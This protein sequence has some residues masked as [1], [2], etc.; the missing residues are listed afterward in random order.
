MANV[1][2]QLQPVCFN[3]QLDW[4]GNKKG[5]LRGDEVQ[6]TIYVATPQ[7]FGGEGKDWSPEHLFLGSLSSCFMATFLNLA[8]KYQLPVSNFSCAASGSVELVKGIYEFTQVDLYPRVHI[9][10]E[11]HR[12]KAEQ[13]LLKTSQY[14]LIAGALKC[15]LL[16][17]T[18]IYVGLQSKQISKKMPMSI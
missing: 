3:T 11:L 1:L 4:I 12:G 9:M 5:I 14:C 16:Y 18:E 15:R 10:D 2:Q 8:R 17:N 7:Q 13:I 6:G